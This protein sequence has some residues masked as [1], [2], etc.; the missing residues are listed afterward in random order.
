MDDELRAPLRQASVRPYS[1]APHSALLGRGHRG[2][3]VAGDGLG[4]LLGDVA[5]LLGRI[6]D[7]ADHAELVARA[8]PTCARDRPITAMRTTGSTGILRSRPIAS[9]AVT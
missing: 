3:G 8:A 9:Y 5:K 4:E 6:H 7:L 1:S 2:G